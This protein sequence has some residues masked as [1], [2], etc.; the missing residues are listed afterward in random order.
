M[1][2]LIANHHGLASWTKIYKGFY[3]SVTVLQVISEAYTA[4]IYFSIMNAREDLAEGRSPMLMELPFKFFFFLCWLC[5]T[6]LC[7]W[8]WL[9]SQE[10][11]VLFKEYLY[12]F[13][14]TSFLTWPKARSPN[15][16]HDEDGGL[17]SYHLPPIVDSSVVY[18]QGIKL[19]QCTFKQ[20][21][22]FS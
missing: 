12:F 14:E 2:I 5:P 19:L 17:S 22:N 18:L 8:Q 11:R 4:E 3:I 6:L 1:S 15:R 10:M 21:S 20:M 13:S 9:N 16:P 7:H